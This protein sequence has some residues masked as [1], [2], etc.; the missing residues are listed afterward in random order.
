MLNK[1]MDNFNKFTELYGD[2][3]F[4]PIVPMRGIVA[5]PRAMLHLEIGRKKTAR[6]VCFS[7]AS[8]RF[9]GAGH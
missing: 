3:A 6:S 1:N 9:Y 5:F 4:L 7:Y 2:T 8:E